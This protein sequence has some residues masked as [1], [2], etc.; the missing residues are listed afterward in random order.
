MGLFFSYYD[1]IISGENNQMHDLCPSL[2][3]VRLSEALGLYIG[4]NQDENMQSL[5]IRGLDI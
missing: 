5:H 3:N 4:H 2:R 1:I